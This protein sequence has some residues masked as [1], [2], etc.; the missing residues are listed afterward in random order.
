MIKY[1]CPVKRKEREAQAE[2]LNEILETFGWEKYDSKTSKPSTSSQ[3]HKINNC[4][5]NNGK[6]KQNS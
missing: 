2:L 1:E 3:F 6:E 4:K 5:D